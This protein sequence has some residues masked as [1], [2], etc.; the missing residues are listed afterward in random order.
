MK[1]E[2][3]NSKRGASV[4]MFYLYTFLVFILLS[5][6]FSCSTPEVENINLAPELYPTEKCNLTWFGDGKIL[7]IDKNHTLP[8]KI[9]K[10]RL[11]GS[12]DIDLI[13]NGYYE[14]KIIN[15]NTAN[16][17]LKNRNKTLVNFSKNTNGIT[18]QFF[19]K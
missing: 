11:N 4:G 15:C 1:S 5:M 12:S 8:D 10:S 6:L 19:N 17:I 9:L 2:F 18:Y 14:L 13:I 7:L 3:N 16:V